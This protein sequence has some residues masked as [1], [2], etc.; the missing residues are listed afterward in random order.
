MFSSGKQGQYYLPKW[1]VIV[2]VRSKVMK[3]L[4]FPGGTVGKGMVLLLLWYGFDPWL[5]NF[6]HVV[7][8]ARK[9]KKSLTWYLSI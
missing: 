8:M 7:G 2:R 4:E 6:C 9:K 5:I 3:Y 1:I